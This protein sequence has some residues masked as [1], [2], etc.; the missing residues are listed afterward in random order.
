M[1][2]GMEIDRI[3]QLVRLA[4]PVSH[5]WRLVGSKCLSE[6]RR[7]EVEIE[8]RARA[9]LRCPRCQAACGQHDSRKR[10]W[11]HLDCMGLETWITCRIPRANCPEHGVVQL[12][13][14]WAEVRSRFTADFEC[15]VIDWLKEASV[16]AVAKNM[17][18]TW[19]QVYNIQERAVRR[20]LGRR[21]PLE[22]S[23]LGVDETSFKKRHDYVTVISDLDGDVL[24]VQDGRKQ[25]SL[26]SFFRE[27][28]KE[29]LA[30]IEVVAMDMHRPYINAV[31]LHVPGAEYK[32][33]F[34]R[35]HVAKHF[36]DA[37]DK[38]RRQEHRE[39]MAKGDDTLKRTKYHWLKNP[40]N[41][42]RRM[43]TRFN[44]L[45]SMALKVARAWAVKE[46]ASNLWHYKS[47]TWAKKAW[48]KLC[49]WASRTRLE[50]IVK[51]GAS[52]RF[53]LIGI[54]NA[55]VNGV[56]NAA[57]EGINRKIQDIKRRA[58][59]YRNR[60]RFKQ[61]IL[62]HLGGLDLYPRSLATHTKG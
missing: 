62:F 13:V 8:Y 37:V 7:L 28:P 56:T 40:S 19:R 27:L 52:M 51:V 59:G 14:P 6:E 12:A 47:R 48:L 2:L 53:H 15:V 33:A 18:L 31:A 25:E 3:E 22:F 46:A 34:D 45:K 50:P 21:G 44:D 43:R 60:E 1:L 61:A 16:S 39:L 20:G 36:G 42:G 9:V 11:R 17:S 23:R 26:E 29:R 35:F 32:I 54:I 57:A 58:N 55:I 10:R 38:V 30:A 5:P 41:M 49:D 4:L 24:D